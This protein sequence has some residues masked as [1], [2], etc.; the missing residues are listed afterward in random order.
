MELSKTIATTAVVLGVI[1]ATGY[2]Q[3]DTVEMKQGEKQAAPA[4]AIKTAQERIEEREAQ[5]RAAVYEQEKRKEAY[6]RACTKPLRNDTDRELCRVAY[7]RLHV[8]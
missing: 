5:R 2:A 8:K 4:G 7:K 1:L 3:G 6:E